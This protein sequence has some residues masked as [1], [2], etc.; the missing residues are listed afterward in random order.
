MSE[1]VNVMVLPEKKIV[2]IH[3][4][5]DEGGDMISI[6]RFVQLL[7]KKLRKDVSELLKL[8][9][10][11]QLIMHDSERPVSYFLLDCLPW[12][13]YT[14]LFACKIPGYPQQLFVQGAQKLMCVNGCRTGFDVKQKIKH[15]LKNIPLDQMWLTC[16]GRPLKD[17][18]SLLDISDGTNIYLA[19]RVQGG[20]TAV[21]FADVGD[22]SGPLTQQWN[23]NAPNWRIAAK[24][25]SL[26]GT[27][28]NSQCKAH[29]KV[30]VMNQYYTDFDLIHEAYKCKCP[31]CDGH[32]QPTICGFNNCE[33]KVIYCKV[34]AGE[35]PERGI[36]DLTS[37]GDEYKTYT[38]DN[39]GT[40]YFSALKI[41]CL[42]PEKSHLCVACGDIIDLRDKKRGPCGH[43][44]HDG[45]CYEKTID[46]GCPV[47]DGEAKMTPHQM[48]YKTTDKSIETVSKL[49]DS[50]LPHRNTSDDSL[51]V[52]LRNKLKHILPSFFN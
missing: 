5:G 8:V 26:E 7:A 24:G 30:V 31:M 39:N 11:D 43:S 3:L 40:A 22:K 28:T 52:Q 10:G 48:S 14:E 17:D 35:R 41:V 9:I 45:H 12:Y 49:T 4:P 19:R 51:F 1:A 27:C 29:N 50:T 34:V 21:P 44:F 16:Q 38:P 47:C 13:V 15:R 6:K 25:L 20:I 46:D 23:K 32:V 18:D 33:Y 42:D 37:V 36:P 2:C